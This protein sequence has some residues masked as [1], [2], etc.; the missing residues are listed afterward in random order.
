MTIFLSRQS[1][2]DSH[3]AKSDYLTSVSESYTVVSTVHIA[4]PSLP[5]SWTLCKLND[6]NI[7]LFT[8]FHLPSY[9]VTPATRTT[10][11][12]ICIDRPT[13]NSN[14]LISKTFYA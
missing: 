1:C 13:P 6:K 7:L 10:P 12:A 4:S 2:S 11:S 14:F 5:Y 9:K 3:N 8:F